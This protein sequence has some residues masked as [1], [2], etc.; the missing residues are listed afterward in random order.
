[1]PVTSNAEAVMRKTLVCLKAKAFTTKITKNMKESISPGSAYL[2]GSG[3]ANDV[4]A[5]SQESM[6]VMTAG[7]SRLMTEVPYITFSGDNVR[8]LVTDVGVFAKGGGK[9]RFTLTA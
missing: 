5:T 9:D 8:T 6:V 1:M 7:K 2:V 4:A 3:G